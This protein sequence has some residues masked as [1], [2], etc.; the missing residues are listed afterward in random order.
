VDIHETGTFTKLPNIPSA[1]N[2]AYCRLQS[3]RQSL[4]FRPRRLHWGYWPESSRQ[5]I[6]VLGETR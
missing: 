5:A 3:F 4:C 2:T 6:A 1:T